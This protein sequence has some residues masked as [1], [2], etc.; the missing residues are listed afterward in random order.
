VS[1]AIQSI[2][3]W[4]RLVYPRDGHGKIFA[5]FEGYFDDSGSHSGA[6]VCV[7]G[8]YYGHENSWKSFSKSW[9]KVLRKFGVESFHSKR[10]YG[11][12]RGGNR[13]DDYVG[14]DEKKAEDFMD[15]LLTVIC[16]DKLYP[17]G[18][19]VNLIDWDTF[20]LADKKILTGGK[21]IKD[22]WR[23]EGKFTKPMFLP[24]RLVVE[25]SAD[26]CPKDEKVHYFFGIDEAS[27]GWAAQYLAMLKD[28]GARFSSRLGNIVGAESK[29]IPLQAADLLAYQLRG[30]AEAK[31]SSPVRVLPNSIIGRA[32]SRKK[33]NGD[34]RIADKQ[35]MKMLLNPRGKIG[36]D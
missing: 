20:S 13:I 15:S 10:F 31:I 22:K 7:M 35:S 6:K 24:F 30:Y 9:D 12:D 28:S 14:W 11:R 26:N 23:A 16:R 25:K 32:T 21:Y 2:R 4:S 29:A 18:Y 36:N 1:G 34:F 3:E 19:A 5:V 8:G 17:L 27:L 33:E